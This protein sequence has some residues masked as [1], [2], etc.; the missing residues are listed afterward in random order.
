[1]TPAF[2]SAFA[3]PRLK[4]LDLSAK[5]TRISESSCSP[6][7]INSRR[8]GMQTGNGHG[9]PSIVR[10]KLS[11]PKKADPSGEGAPRESA[12]GEEFGRVDVVIYYAWIL[13]IGDV[14]EPA[15]YR[16]VEAE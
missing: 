10:K 13:A 14:I 11:P 4:S 12:E 9:P 1:V 16:P 7:V 3:I 2:D 8:D 5:P 6:P 15:A